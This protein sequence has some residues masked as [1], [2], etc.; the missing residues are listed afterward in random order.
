[1]KKL[2]A[3]LLAIGFILLILVAPFIPIGDPDPPTDDLAAVP[4]EAGQEQY[5]AHYAVG[6]GYEQTGNFSEAKAA[7]LEASKASQSEIISAVDNALERTLAKEA[8]PFLQWQHT[9]RNTLW[10][11]LQAAAIVI[12][13]LALV[14]LGWQIWRWRSLRKLL[15][16]YLFTPFDDFIAD[17]PGQGA[18]R[19][20]Q[21]I[22]TDI[23]QVQQEADARLHAAIDR[24]AFPAFG[25][26][27]KT[28]TVTEE[29]TRVVQQVSLAGVEI[30]LPALLKATRY[31]G[32]Q[33]E[34]TLNG[35]LFQQGDRVRLEATVVCTRDMHEVKRWTLLGT[36]GDAPAQQIGTLIEELAYRFLRWGAKDRLGFKTWTALRS[37]TEGLR[38]RR[39]YAITAD[40]QYIN[41][42]GDHLFDAT[43]A[44]PEAFPAIY[45]LGGIFHSTGQYKMAETQYRLIREFD[46]DRR[47]E[48]TYN[49]GV[50]LLHQVATNKLHEAM[51]CFDEIVEALK[52]T[53]IED[54]QRLLLAMTYGSMALLHTL[55]LNREQR[56]WTKP[57]D[58]DR[59]VLIKERAEQ[60]LSLVSRIPPGTEATDMEGIGDNV[61]HA[62][63]NHALGRMEAE[64]AQ[65]VQKE[66]FAAEK[67]GDETEANA[68]LEKQSLL[69]KQSRQKLRRAIELDPSNPVIYI[70]LA[71]TFPQ[72]SDEHLHWLET[73][74]KVLP[75]F[76]YGWLQLGIAHQ[77]R[78][79]FDEAIDAY[80]RAS[81][82]ADANSS[83]GK[84]LIKRDGYA[85][86]MPYLLKAIKLDPRDE[87]TYRNLAWYTL[88][89]METGEIPL[90]DDQLDNV[91]AWSRR[92]HDLL[93]SQKPG[94]LWRAHDLLGWAF[95][96]QGNFEPAQ[97]EL[98]QANELSRSEEQ[99]AYHLAQL[100][101]A[102]E[103]PAIALETLKKIKTNSPQWR[104]KID[105]LTAQ[106][107]TKIS[108]TEI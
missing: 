70:S 81:Q 59:E 106:L 79:A 42:A 92:A 40:P 96:L 94:Q 15:P 74:V 65:R 17:N 84:L 61:V 62:L 88:E 28:N 90:D 23:E 73:A 51:D 10:G 77:E 53:P 105:S 54:E 26:P 100:Y 50:S 45:A 101:Q 38:A 32:L 46:K 9:M 56:T 60:A 82:F 11:V 91:I 47:P 63:V 29:A 68:H 12:L 41:I 18:H 30:N 37:Y 66:A 16:G 103:K 80:R 27:A 8:N 76:E 107:Q 67:S 2:L 78:R 33:K 55:E 36:P 57:K 7:Y 85:A 22:L 35:A 52:E 48:A 14:W 21:A 43:I 87:W 3:I 6:L 102:W 25:A 99:V 4:I 44:D 89:A 86:G 104:K 95:T 39:Q 5:I 1:M 24:A 83:L 58:G 49:L 75:H 64:L 69:L 34:F 19:L 72:K 98:N 13:L 97:K 71:D 20:L 93:Q 31:L 108:D